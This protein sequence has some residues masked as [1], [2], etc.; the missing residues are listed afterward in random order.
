MHLK[1]RVSGSDRNTN[2]AGTHL[3]GQCPV[4]QHFP[5]AP[6][7]V[8]LES[9][10]WPR[11]FNTNTLPQYNRDYDPKEL[12]MKFEAAVESNGGDVTTKTKVLVTALKGELQY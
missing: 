8:E 11:C 6:L 3:A 12:L 9:A 4:L 2:K 7:S 5:S 10:L 1:V